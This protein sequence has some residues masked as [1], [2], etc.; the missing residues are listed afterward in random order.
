MSKDNKFLSWLKRPYGVW[1]VLLYI[2][3]LF[4]VAGSV[5]CAVVLMG[6]DPVFEIVSYGVFGVTAVLFGYSLYT[7]VIY[8]PRVKQGIIGLLKKNRF[9]A[10]MLEEFSFKTMVFSTLSLVLTVAFAIMN[11]VSAIK[12]RLIWYG[13]LFG[14]Y[15]A[16]IIFRGGVLGSAKRCAHKYGDDEAAYEFAVWKIYRVSGA[17]LILIEFAMAGAVTQMMLSKRPNQS[18]QIMA[19]ANAAY[20]FIKVTLAVINM[21]KARRNFDPVTQSLRNLNFADACMSVVSLTVLMLTVFGDDGLL[22]IKACVGFAACI[23]TLALAVYMI[24]KSNRELKRLKRSGDIGR[25]E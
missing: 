22:G 2:I 11:L 5:V 7:V 17:I 14:Y 15:V 13:A 21:F 23:L 4:A 25:E 8:V 18:G 10:K 9:T 24:I 19:I 1:L 3:T 12:Y 20:T 6:L 16:L